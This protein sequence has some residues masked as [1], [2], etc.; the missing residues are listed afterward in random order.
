MTT[1]AKSGHPT[2]CGSLADFIAAYNNEYK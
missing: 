1:E 2:S